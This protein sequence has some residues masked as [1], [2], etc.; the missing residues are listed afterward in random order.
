M[1]TAEGRA[2][3]RE[4]LLESARVDPEITAAA[5]VGS[6]ATGAEDDWSDIDL[7]FRLAPGVAPRAAVVDCAT[8]FRSICPS[9]R[10]ASSGPPSR[11]SACCSARRGEPTEPSPPQPEHLTGMGWLYA[12]HARS[13]IARNRPWQA[14]LMLD[15][16]R[17]QIIALACARHG[18]NP[19]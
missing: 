18:L 7:A 10:T 4:A 16:M 8:H 5:V 19:G 3:L 9:G 6:G 12:L 11:A 14:V 2:E 15:G 17:D 1:F 13:S